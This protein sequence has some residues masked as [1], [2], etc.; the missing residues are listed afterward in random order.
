MEYNLGASQVDLVVKNTPAN[1][2]DTRDLGS[3]PGS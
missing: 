1:A 3:I 2:G